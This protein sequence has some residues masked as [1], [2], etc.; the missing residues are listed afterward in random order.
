MM[1]LDIIFLH[2]SCVWRSFRILDLWVITF[3]T[4]GDFFSSHFF[5]LLF[6]C[7]SHSL[8]C[9]HSSYAYTW[10]LDVAPRFTDA[11]FIKLKNFF[12][13]F[14]VSFCLVSIKSSKIT[15]FYFYSVY[16]HINFIQCI[17]HLSHCG[18]L[19]ASSSS[20]SLINTI[21]LS[22][23]FLNMGRII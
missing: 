18:F 3:I 2:A 17:L 12:F 5:L 10:P 7:P 23:S 13:L 22:S 15:D 14:H 20:T 8:S 6:L 11:L 9:R 21:S 16:D 4:F 1:C 19:S